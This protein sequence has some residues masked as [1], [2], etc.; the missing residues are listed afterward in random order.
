MRFVERSHLHNLK[1]EV[2]SADEEATTTNYPDLAKNISEDDYTK[3]RIFNAD[4]IAFYWKKMPCNTFIDRKEKS[5][6]VFNVCLYLRKATYSWMIK[7]TFD[8]D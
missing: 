4:K 3:Q 2:A 7:V 8:S 6:P 5:I 1:G